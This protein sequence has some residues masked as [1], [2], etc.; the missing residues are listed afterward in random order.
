MENGGGWRWHLLKH[1]NC[2]NRHTPRTCTQALLLEGLP[3]A[4]SVLY[5][6]LQLDI[7]TGYSVKRGQER[8]GGQNLGN[9]SRYSNPCGHWSPTCWYWGGGG[10]LQRGKGGWRGRWGAPWSRPPPT[11]APHQDHASCLSL[12]KTLSDQRGLLNATCHCS[13]NFW[14]PWR[15]SIAKESLG[16]CHLGFHTIVNQSPNLLES[17]LGKYCFP[18][19]TGCSYS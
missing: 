18:W 16:G 10:R 13:P 15:G 11:L 1:W 12:I 3:P 6:N 4:A 19:R 5:F 2:R 9:K 14:R 7:Y 8:R 17:P